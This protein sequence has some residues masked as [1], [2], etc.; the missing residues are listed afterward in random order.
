MMVK[1]SQAGSRLI[2]MQMV[3]RMYVRKPNVEASDPIIYH[4]MIGKLL[5]ATISPWPDIANNIRSLS[6]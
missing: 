4:S 1:L 6:R 3:M 5:M 2:A